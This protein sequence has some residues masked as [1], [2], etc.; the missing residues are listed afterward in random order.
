MKKKLM[1]R[2]MKAAAATSHQLDWFSE[3]G[4]ELFDF[5]F[6]RSDGSLPA[7]AERNKDRAWI[8]KARGWMVMMNVKERREIFIC[9][10]WSLGSHRILLLDDLRAE[11][12]LALVGDPQFG[13]LDKLIIETSSGNYQVWLALPE[14]VDRQTRKALER[15][16]VQKFGGDPNSADGCHF[17]RCAGFQNR[18]PNR[19]DDWVRVAE[20]HLHQPRRSFRPVHLPRKSDSERAREALLR[21]HP[22]EVSYHEWIKVA[23]ALH[24]LSDGEVIWSEWN[25]QSGFPDIE[26]SAPRVWKSTQNNRCGLGS[27]F[28]V[29][30]KYGG[31]MDVVDANQPA[32]KAQEPQEQPAAPKL[33]PVEILQH[34]ERLGVAIRSNGQDFQFM[35]AAGTTV[36]ELKRLIEQGDREALLRALRPPE[37]VGMRC[38]PS[39]AGDEIGWVID[40]SRVEFTPC[41]PVCNQ[42]E[43][44]IEQCAA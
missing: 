25:Q 1:T 31:R 7:R 22:D 20:P 3:H 10:S 26:K 30:R 5:R 37:R 38:W 27:I 8:G 36:E 35:P 9:P 12:V 23:A 14:A 17:G 41:W 6:V 2:T 13:A 43:V 39:L 28:H 19:N 42:D 29:A 33:S 32:S 18:K 4:I 15:H 16:L 21:V 11:A 24:E 44:E 40:P 34:A